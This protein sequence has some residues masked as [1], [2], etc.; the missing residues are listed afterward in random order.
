[1]LQRKTVPV[2]EDLGDAAAMADMPIGLV[3]EQAAR[4]LLCYGGGLLKRQLGLGAGEPQLDDPPKA[5]P[6]PAPVGE[7]ALGRGAERLEMEITNPCRVDRGGKLMLRKAGPPR[8]RSVAH[9]DQHGDPG[10][11]KRRH[12]IGE[13]RLLIADRQ[14][15]RRHRLD[16]SHNKNRISGENRN[17]FLNRLG[18]R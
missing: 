16:L 18:R 7:A 5:L 12:D 17:L 9:I 11:G 15:S 13:P 6:L 4:A 8:D 10:G 1:M 3:A 14:E 2:G